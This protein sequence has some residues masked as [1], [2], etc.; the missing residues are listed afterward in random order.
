VGAI[1]DNEFM[2]MRCCVHIL[3]L[4][5]K[6]HFTPL[7]YPRVGDLALNVPKLLDDPPELANVWQV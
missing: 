5:G 7:F 6:L 4:M 2:H 1:L 3:N